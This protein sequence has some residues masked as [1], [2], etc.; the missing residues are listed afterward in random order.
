MRLR[1][2]QVQVDL[3]GARAGGGRSGTCRSPRYLLLVSVWARKQRLP[4]GRRAARRRCELVEVMLMQSHHCRATS[5]AGA[6]AACSRSWTCISAADGDRTDSLRA[7]ILRTSRRRVRERRDLARRTS[8]AA[9]IFFATDPHS[10]VSRRFLK[11][12]RCRVDLPARRFYGS[13]RPRSEFAAVMTKIN[14]QR[15]T[16][17]RTGRRSFDSLAAPW[18]TACVS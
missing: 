14:A 16:G 4:V 8:A 10:P 6:S 2:L 15:P 9:G 13:W 1:W 3:P 11:R 17:R 5:S 18:Q 7:V 12:R